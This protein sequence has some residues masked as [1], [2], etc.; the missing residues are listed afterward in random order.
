MATLNESQ[1]NHVGFMSQF[2]PLGTLEQSDSRR[3]QPSLW[4]IGLLFRLHVAADP[5]DQFMPTL[6]SPTL[7][8]IPPSLWRSHAT[9][10]SVGIRTRASLGQRSSSE[11][12]AITVYVAD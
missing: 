2:I 12:M 10:A 3:S 11:Y 5:N 6:E 9:L 1:V 7:V 8:K 4:M